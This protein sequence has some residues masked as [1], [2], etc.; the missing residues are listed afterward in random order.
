MF[1][2]VMSLLLI[3]NEYRIALSINN[4]FVVFLLDFV[5]LFTW[6]TVNLPTPDIDG[7][8]EC[9]FLLGLDTL[10]WTAWQLKCFRAS[11]TKGKRFRGSLLICNCGE[12][13]GLFEKDGLLEVLTKL[14]LAEIELLGIPL[15]LIRGL[16]LSLYCAA[17]VQLL[18]VNVSALL[19]LVEV[20]VAQVAG[21][22]CAAQLALITSYLWLRRSRMSAIKH[23]HNYWKDWDALADI[24]M[25]KK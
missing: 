16:E 1:F 15:S 13:H 3:V 10:S 6:F 17:F 24:V 19:V 9:I 4:I 5:Y 14:S 25:A 11:A 23:N 21:A 2:N 22:V 12:F 18:F 20:E 8:V 7:G